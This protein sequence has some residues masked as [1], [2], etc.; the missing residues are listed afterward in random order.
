MPKLTKRVVE[1]AE[2]R[3]TEYFIWCD[4][5]P[6]F[7]VRIYPSGRRGYLVQYRAD[8]RTRRTKIG[9]HGPLTPD[10]ARREAMAMLG[11]VAKGGNPAEER[12]TRRASMTVG[13]LCERYHDAASRGLILGKGGGPKKPSTLSRDWSRMQRHVLPLFGQSSGGRSH[14]GR[15]RP[16]YARCERRQ[17]GAG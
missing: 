13:E 8:G 14:R 10:E 3:S 9:L 4:E 16:I 17:D 12:A 2:V 7:G 6:G 1:A 5:L 15:Y 11:S